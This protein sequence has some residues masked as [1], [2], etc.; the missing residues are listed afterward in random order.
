MIYRPML[1]FPTLRLRSSFDDLERMRQQMDRLMASFSGQQS[2]DRSAGV[3]PLVNL[4]EDRDRFYLR[5]ELPGVKSEDLEIQAERNTI[6]LSGARK[7][8]AE[9]GDVKYHRR[10]REAGTFSRIIGLPGEIDP[11]KVAANLAN[12]ILTITIPKA[13]IAKPKQINVKS[14]S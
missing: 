6:S 3:F 10:E 11:D 7:V 14:A 9:G 1:S 5:A 8:G 12:G 2:Q 4:T 13:E